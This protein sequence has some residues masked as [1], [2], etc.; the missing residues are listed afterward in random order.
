MLE[1]IKAFETATNVKVPYKIG[2]RRPGDIPTSFND[3]TAATNEL[4]WQA[5]L[6][7]ED[8]CRD[9]WHWQQKNPSGYK[10]E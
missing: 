4:G 1:I 2:P 5:E 9:A 7:I 8:I 3:P 6:G 10:D